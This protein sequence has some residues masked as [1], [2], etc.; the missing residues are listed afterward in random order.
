MKIVYAFA[1]FVSICVGALFPVAGYGQDSFDV[2]IA[3]TPYRIS[4]SATVGMLTGQAEEIV[5]K[6]AERD[7]K[8]SQLL[9]DLKPM[10]YAGSALS[11]SRSDPLAGPGVT[12]DLSVKF[13]LPLPSGAL[14]DRDWYDTNLWWS[15]PGNPKYGLDDPD[16]KCFS[17]HTIWLEGG[18]L[19][20]DVSGGIT[21]P[22]QS[23]VTLKALFA[24]SYMQFSWAG[25][26]GYGKYMINDWKREDFNGTVI[27]YQQAWL[28]FAPGIGIFWPFHRA[29]SLDFR[30]FI[31]PLIYAGAEDTHIKRN[32]RFNDYMEGG[33]FLEPGLD[34]AFSPNRFFSLLLHGSWRHI[35]G[36]RGDTSTNGSAYLDKDLAGAGFAAFD[37]GLSFKFALP[38]GALGKKNKRVQ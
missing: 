23:A 16:L 8:M 1:L 6:Y 17:T 19:L 13:G 3:K 15:D 31:S 22:I 25:K 33:L 7:D 20:F 30:F 2:A 26:D 32:I 4:L 38:L 36:T 28:I 14:E 29:L 12:L 5:Y 11:F 21:I 37:A 10:V 27:T 24:L 18:T 35:V 9:W 34:I